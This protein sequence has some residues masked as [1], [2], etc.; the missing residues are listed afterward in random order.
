[1]IILVCCF[2]RVSATIENGNVQTTNSSKNDTS[3]LPDPHGPIARLRH[4]VRNADHPAPG[5]VSLPDDR[6][7]SSEADTFRL[8]RLK[9]LQKT[10]RGQNYILSPF[11]D[12]NRFGQN[13]VHVST[14]QHS[15][16]VQPENADKEPIHSI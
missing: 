1:M 15:L 4:P 10:E 16:F 5:P 6:G 13:V 9:S 12:R 8:T 11:P 2:A 7:R 14:N 3:S